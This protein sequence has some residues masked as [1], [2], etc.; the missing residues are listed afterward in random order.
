MESQA[1]CC[2]SNQ[3][4]LASV[5]FAVA[6]IAKLVTV[7]AISLLCPN[8]FS[9]SACVGRERER[10][11]GEG[12]REREKL[13][14]CHPLSFSTLCFESGS[15]LNMERVIL[16]RPGAPGPSCLS[17]QLLPAPRDSF[18]V[19]LS[20]YPAFVLLLRVWTPVLLRQ[21]LN[22]LRPPHSS[23]TLP[24]CEKRLLE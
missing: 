20:P 6:K 22:P 12:G 21:V 23:P 11:R 5:R 16:S 4:K 8:P 24:F 3:F 18:K 19:T 15:T 2:F 13:T 14:K 10:E 9:S 7:V 1:S 17:S